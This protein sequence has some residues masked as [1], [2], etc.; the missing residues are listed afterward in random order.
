MSA[1]TAKGGSLMPSLGAERSNQPHSAPGAART[2][3][4]R[5]SHSPSRACSSGEVG[6][7]GRVVAARTAGSRTRAAA[8]IQLD[9]HPHQVEQRLELLAVLGAD[10]ARRMLRLGACPGVRALRGRM[11]HSA[12]RSLI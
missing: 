9:R 7:Q 11:R 3:L 12:R 6:A 2:R 5:S 10:H 8:V 4:T 1:P